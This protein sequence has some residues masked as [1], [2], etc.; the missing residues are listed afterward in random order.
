MCLWCVKLNVVNSKIVC[1]FR[2]SFLSPRLQLG[3][4][5]VSQNTFTNTDPFRWLENTPWPCQLLHRYPDLTRT[6]QDSKQ[7]SF[8]TEGILQICNYSNILNKYCD[9]FLD[10]WQ[11]ITMCIT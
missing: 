10:S 6:L 3:S 2:G 9:Q 11:K 5:L 8:F 7:Q 1:T 4:E